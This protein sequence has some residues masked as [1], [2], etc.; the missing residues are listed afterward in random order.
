MTLPEVSR[1]EGLGAEAW[2]ALGHRL[3]AVDFEA[4]KLGWYAAIC[5]RL[6][7]PMQ[8]PMRLY[9]LR[10]R[11]DAI[12]CALRMFVLGD[13]LT[14]EH[15]L[16]LLGDLALPRL[17]D[18]GLLTSGDDGVRSLFR[19]NINGPPYVLCDDL[20]A[21][22]EAVMGAATTT[23]DLVRA[24]IASTGFERVLDLGCGAGTAA[25]FL[26]PTSKHVIATD[27]NPR[28]IPLP[29]VNAMLNGF[30]NVEA[31]VG[32]LFAPVAGETFDLVVSQPPFVPRPE[33][34][35]S[36][37]YLYGG[38]RGDELAL[39]LLRELPPVLAKG[40]RAVLLV[41]WPIVDDEPLQE[42]LRHAVADDALSVLLMHAVEVNL[43]EWSS[44]HASMEERSLGPGFE[45]R[46]MQLR[47][48]FD[49]I[50]ARTL[51]VT[52]SVIA[53]T[54]E[55]GWTRTVDILPF[56]RALVTGDHVAALVAT[57]ELAAGS[58]ERLLTARLRM[59]PGAE[60][61]ERGGRFRVVFRDLLAPV[62][63]SQGAAM[64]TRAAH[65]FE[66][67]RK[68]I[69]AI[70]AKLGGRDMTAQ[71]LAGI[72]QALSLGVL[73]LEGEAPPSGSRGGP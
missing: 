46:A 30:D 54:G 64:L 52:L 10:K 38:R 20:S 70:S 72:R 3:R 37:T 8:G 65:D 24:A 68:A 6:I 14:R 35:T 25:L 56:S 63:L 60:L 66:S 57:S 50:G 55:K 44:A 42:R 31:R 43:D 62:E 61:Q 73:Q 41:D 15:T 27:I 71:G 59:P 39:R 21:G 2:R 34:A 12:A 28:A 26:A 45:R 22:G 7:E 48:H 69:E 18:A 19:L 29:R 16:S 4:Q 17:L 33:G 1:L 49:S 58:D 47:A 11:D 51:C 9:H 67:V 53:R 5:E 36:A 40:G 13:V 23:A 32:D